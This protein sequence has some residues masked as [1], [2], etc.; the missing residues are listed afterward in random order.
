M[1]QDFPASPALARV[2]RGDLCAGC[3]GCAA[4]APGKVRMRLAEPGYL[5]PVQEA[6]LSPQEEDGIAAVCPGLG[7]QV[8][9]GERTDTVLWGPYVSIM[10]GWATDPETRFAASSGGALSALLVHLVESGRVDAVV[11][12]TA[13]PDLPIGNAATV[14]TEAGA[15]RAAAG[16]RY[17]PSAPL[18]DLPA[19]L[20]EHRE[21]G[22]RF[23]FVGKPCDAVALRAWARRDPR[24]TGPSRWWCRSSA[25]ACRPMRAVG[26][27]SRR[28]EP[29]WKPPVPSATA[30]RAGPAAPPPPPWTAPNGR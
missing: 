12:T 9:T 10:T 25:R 16:S 19:R 1:P 3:G 2:A 21:T 6:P 4:L 20:A 17:A 14:S 13:D 8:E 30:G 5:R 11:Q 18:A 26:P 15:I 28:S 23:A 24:S 7:Q 27:S 29:I 22:R